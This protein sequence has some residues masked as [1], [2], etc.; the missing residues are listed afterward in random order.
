M[1][2]WI[3]TAIALLFVFIP[4]GIVL[5]R[6]TKLPECLMAVQLIQVTSAL[7]LLLLAHGFARP[8]FADLG[9]LLA[10]LSF[11]SGLLIAQ[12]LERWLP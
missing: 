7:V 3:V 11:P 12:F 10:L 4:C 1:N 2:L 5:I 9:L 6:S 8:G